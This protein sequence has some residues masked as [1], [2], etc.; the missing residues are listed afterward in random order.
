MKGISA[1]IAVVLILMITVALSAAAYVWFTGVFDTITQGASEAAEGTADTISTQFSIAAVNRVSGSLAQIV[2][3]NTGSSNIDLSKMNIIVNNQLANKTSA[4]TGTLEVGNVITIE[5]N[6]D[7][8]YKGDFCGVEI[9]VIYGSLNQIT[10][11]PACAVVAVCGDGVI[12][13]TEEC[14]GTNLGTYGDGV[15]QCVVYDAGLYTAGDLGCSS[16][17]W[18]VSGCS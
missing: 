14:D 15:D 10:S 6:N 3:A 2:V 13:G 18:D 16:C 7:G 12:E 5:I 17:A 8:A 11:L 4:I 9:K 1:V